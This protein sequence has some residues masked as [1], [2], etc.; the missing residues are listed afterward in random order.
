MRVVSLSEAP[1]PELSAA[2]E[3]F[4]EGFTYPLGPGRWF[5]ISHGQDYA[6]FFRAMGQACCFI[7][8][9]EG[10]V[11]GTIG[12]ALKTMIT[13][14]GERKPILYLGDLKVAP[15]ARGGRCLL[16][17]TEAVQ[18]WV[19]GRAEAA[20]SVVM[21][22]TPATPVDYSGRLGIPKFSPIAKINVLRI[23]ASKSGEEFQ[24]PL[25]TNERNGQP[26]FL[27]LVREQGRFATEGS[28]PGERSEMTPL[29]LMKPDGTACGLLEDTRKGKRLITGEGE[30]MPSAHLTSFAY[31]HSNHGAD[32]IK[33]GLAL[34]LRNGYPALFVAIPVEATPAFCEHL[35]GREIVTAPATVYG[36]GLPFGTRWTINTA[37]I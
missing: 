20:F 28:A 31:T 25:I 22:G 10:R 30:E 15:V 21:D 17:L 24:E 27:R 6:R 33:A 9:R 14:D 34:A 4:E 2:L 35:L 23:F 3:V 8:A 19:K 37:E 13:P 5:R 29:W 32:L 18:D 7:A 26:C 36:S 11:L 1:G 12:A 16:A